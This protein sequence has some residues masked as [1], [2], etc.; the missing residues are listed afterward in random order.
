MNFSGRGEKRPAQS[1]G[2]ARGRGKSEEEGP[3][4]RATAF[5]RQPSPLVIA[6]QPSIKSRSNESAVI[7]RIDLPLRRSPRPDPQEDSSA[8][9]GDTFYRLDRDH[10]LPYIFPTFHP[11]RSP[12]PRELTGRERI[13]E[14]ARRRRRRGREKEQV[15]A[16]KR[17]TTT[18][19]GESHRPLPMLIS[20]Y[21]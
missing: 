5:A 15:A 2:G 6:G 20:G 14:K 17:R 19:Q 18:S 1:G 10:D 4:S 9:G 12:R 21:A 3:F 13:E 7:Y 8:S 11:A 16:G